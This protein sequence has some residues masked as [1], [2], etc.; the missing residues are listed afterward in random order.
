MHWSSFKQPLITNKLLVNEIV[1]EEGL[2]PGL[3]LNGCVG[4]RDERGLKSTTEI[5]GI[6]LRS[7]SLTMLWVLIAKIKLMS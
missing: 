7:T 3:N 4:N 2:V 5:H 6:V 1:W